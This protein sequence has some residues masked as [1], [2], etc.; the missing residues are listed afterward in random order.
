M[1]LS[2]V[3]TI[4]ILSSFF[5]APV[6]AQQSNNTVTYRYVL[7]LSENSLPITRIAHLHFNNNESVF[8]HTKGKNGTVI[9]T[10]DGKDWDGKN[11]EDNLDSWYQDTIGVVIFKNLK[12]RKLCVREFYYGTALLV[13][14][15]VLPT[16]KWQ[17]TTEKKSIGTFICQKATARFRG[18]NYISWF[19]MDI[20]VSNGPWKLQGLP[21]LILEATDEAGEI[22]FL[23]SSIEMPSSD[24]VSIKQP[25]LG[26]KIDFETYKKADAI[27]YKNHERAMMSL[28][29]GRNAQMTMTRGKVNLIEKEYE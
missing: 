15:P 22:Q 1:K 21:G 23:F 25:T 26:K 7:K 18:R 8:S 27:E 9:K 19:T 16:I 29:A 13:D 12:N 10:A 14:E 6:S 24:L 28:M 11:L 2:F 17:I 20:P 3:Y 4:I 5:P